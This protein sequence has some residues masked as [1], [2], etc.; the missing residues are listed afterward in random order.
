MRVTSLQDVVDWRLCLGCG[1]CAYICPE[2]KI[3][4]FDFTDEG[5]R[6][7]IEDGNCADCRDCLEVCPA[8]RSDFRQDAG[9]TKD[10]AYAPDFQ[11]DWGPVTGIWEGYAT[12]SE[13]RYKGSS[14]GALTALSAYCLEQLG[15]HGALQIAADPENPLRNL[16]RLSR[17]RAE[18]LA[19]AGSR[20]APA[21]VGNGLGLVEQ[22]PAPCVIIGKPAEI[23]A[24]RNARAM[25]Q[26]LDHNVGVTLSFFCAESPATR[27]TLALLDR[28]GAS[29]EQ[30]GEL[31]YRG[32]GWPGHF[33]PVL[34]GEIK[35]FK[36][37]TY[38]ESWAFLQA[39]RPWSVHQWPD[40]SGELADISCGDPWYEEPDGRNPGFSLVVA[41]T[42]LGREIV[43]GA[44]RAGYLELSVAEP[45]KLAKSQPNLLAKK[46]AVWGRR[47]AS[48]RLRLPVTQLPGLD[49]K[50]CWNALTLTEKLK[51]TLGTIRR[52]IQRRL[53][54]R[55]QLNH[56]EAAR[57]PSLEDSSAIQ[58][59]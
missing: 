59:Q 4:L 46:G 12:D 18:L 42:A 23:S 5:I 27:G 54:R 20:Y 8:V 9:G 39:H 58:H 31:R 49:L 37:L 19:A 52:L 29:P 50:R 33:A 44:I 32:Y 13:I 21:C 16:T 26:R 15:M 6:P 10:S 45:W 30:V 35:P 41:R 51:S 55:L 28:L 2:S 24:L 25:R 14:G 53:Y 3:T 38:R 22:A 57:V 1:A 56:A 43:E 40:G 47:W 36:R 17:S 48:T 34:R 11:A 7:V